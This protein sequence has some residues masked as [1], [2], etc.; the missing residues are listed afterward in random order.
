MKKACNCPRCLGIPTADRRWGFDRAKVP[1]I[2]CLM[3]GKKIGRSR[4]LLNLT[5]ARFG[6]MLFVHARCA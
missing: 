5:L 1:N 6:Q 2:E 3:C 4:Y